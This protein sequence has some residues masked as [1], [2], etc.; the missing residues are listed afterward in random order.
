MPRRKKSRIQMLAELTERVS[1]AAERARLD[2]ADKRRQVRQAN[3]AKLT[4]WHAARRA[5]RVREKA[6]ANHA[7]RL[8]ADPGRKD[9]RR[10]AAAPG[11]Q[12]VLERMEPGRW[13]ARGELEAL[14]APDYAAGSVRAWVAQK[15]VAGGLVERAPNADFD[16]TVPDRRQLE[17]RWLYRKTAA[18]ASGDGKR[19]PEV[20]G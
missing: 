4:E 13:Y 19:A 3:Q 11:W 20:S 10:V 17:P 7:A 9:R 14:G 15:L 18:V 6:E 2:R 12:I 16:A 1:A 8:A 5:E